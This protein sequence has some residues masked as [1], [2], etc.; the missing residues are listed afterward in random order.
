MIKGKNCLFVCLILFFAPIALLSQNDSAL[1]YTKHSEESFISSNKL[2]VIKMSSIS[3]IYEVFNKSLAKNPNAPEIKKLLDSIYSIKNSS[4]SLLDSCNMLI[5][6][7]QTLRKK[8][9]HVEALKL[10]FLLH[11]YFQEKIIE[12]RDDYL[13][14]ACIK[15]NIGRV[16]GENGIWITSLQYLNEALNISENQDNQKGIACALH[17]IGSLYI[18]KDDYTEA[19]KYINASIVINQQLGLKKELFNNYNNLAFIYVLQENLT[20]ALD[21]FILALDQID[22]SDNSNNLT[23]IYT[24]LALVNS[25]L[26]KPQEALAYINLAEKYQVDKISSVYIPETKVE[27]YWRLGM[28]D[29]CMKY[30]NEGLAVYPGIKN[31]SVQLSI[32]KTAY[33]YFSKSEDYKSAYNYSLI[34]QVLKDSIQNINNQLNYSI[35]NTISSINSVEMENNLLKQNLSNEKGSIK[36]KIVWFMFISA[37]LLI[38]LS[39]FILFLRSRKREIKIL[40]KNAEMNAR[41]VQQQKQILLKNEDELSKEIDYKNRQLTSTTL[42]L[43]RYNQ[44]IL[45]TIKELQS[46]ILNLKSHESS[47]QKQIQNIVGELRHFISG[48]NWNEFRLCFEEVHP[49]FYESISSDFPTLTKNELKLCALI[50][51]GLSNKDIASV[52]SRE[53]RSVESAR[54]RLRKKFGIEIENSLFNF[55]SSY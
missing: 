48:N 54:N 13:L 12:K 32:I 33:E 18:Q 27:I 10:F 15:L 24:N 3:E 26:G 2:S 22:K 11:S 37:I 55:L 31:T 47:K 49:S 7:G 17:Y 5:E 4:F 44:F 28:K 20:A 16:Y 41:L 45:K 38:T 50:K 52:I 34:Y 40:T 51:L 19:K 36:Q 9:L 46:V 14:F 1:F 43:A 23:A 39:F 25:K 8:E 53:I 6:V 35:L 29:S 21:Y 42:Q 30:L